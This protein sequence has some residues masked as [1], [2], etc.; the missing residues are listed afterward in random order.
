MYRPDWTVWI[1]T[2]V[3]A[4]IWT[5]H[6]KLDPSDPDCVDPWTDP[7]AIHYPT[8]TPQETN[9]HAET[10]MISYPSKRSNT[11]H[12]NQQ[13]LAT[14]NKLKAFRRMHQ[15]LYKDSASQLHHNPELCTLLATWLIPSKTNKMALKAATIICAL[16]IAYVVA[17][18]S[19]AITCMDVDMCVAPCMSYL[20]GAESSPSAACC[21]GVKRLKSLPSSTD[22]KRFACNCVKQAASKIADIKDDAIKG[23]PTACGTPLPFPISLQFDCST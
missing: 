14:A 3:L 15:L 7:F 21:E 8:P 1:W 9:F 22:E 10:K 16:L 2:I 18:P 6:F 23:L 4:R 12:L 11:L 19:E 20:T 5:N 13:T 17:N